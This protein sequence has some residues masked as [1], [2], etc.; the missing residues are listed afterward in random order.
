MTKTISKT[1]RTLSIVAIFFST[2]AVMADLAITPVIGMIY[3]YYPDHTSAVNYIVSGPMLVLVAASLITPLLTRRF[4]KKTVFIAAAVIFSIGAIFG[5]AA[6]DPLYICFTRTLVGIGEG[7]IN[8]V[9]IAYIADL[10]ENAQDRNKI[11]G[12]SYAIA[13]IT[14]LLLIW[15]PGQATALVIGTICGLTYKVLISY[16]YGHGFS[17]VPASRADDVSSITTAVYGL[18]SFLCTYFATWLMQLMHT[19]LVTPTWYVGAIGFILITVLDIFVA[20]RER[21]RFG[22]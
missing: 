18:G 13:G 10:Y 20:L 8:A 6:D 19:D 15:F 4:N 16:N 7:V 9:G 22:A 21:K 11:T 2:L 14:L 17:I 3:G 1:K 5:A 12:F